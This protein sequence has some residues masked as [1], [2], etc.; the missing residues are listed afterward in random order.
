MELYFE[1]LG[2]G[3]YRACEYPPETWGLSNDDWY[4]DFNAYNIV[5]WMINAEEKRALEDGYD[6]WC[7]IWLRFDPIDGDEMKD[8]ALLGKFPA[9]NLDDAERLLQIAANA[10]YE[11]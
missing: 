5:E 9:W 10:I 3:D 2:C 4:I 1:E 11:E 6:Y 7:D 8:V